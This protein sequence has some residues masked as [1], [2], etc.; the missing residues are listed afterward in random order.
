MVRAAASIVCLNPLTGEVERAAEMDRTAVP[1]GQSDSDP[2]DVGD[3]ESSGILDVSSLIGLAPGR[4]FLFDV[5]AHSIHDG[6]IATGNLVQGGQ[7]AWLSST[8]K[9]LF[10]PLIMKSIDNQPSGYQPL[11]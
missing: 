11:K 4:L 10:L 2:T 6:T 7:I 1:A 5:Q 3:W 9:Q 8:D